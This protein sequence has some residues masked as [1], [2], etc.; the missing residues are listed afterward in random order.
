MSEL[1]GLLSLTAAMVGRPLAEVLSSM[2]ISEHVR[3]ALIEGG[4]PLADVLTLVT[5]YE[6][7]D[8]HQVQGILDARDLEPGRVH[9]VYTE[10]LRCA[11]EAAAF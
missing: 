11:R 9:A 7:S 2:T 4:T 5:A 10:S 1:T 6:R 8:W 3:A